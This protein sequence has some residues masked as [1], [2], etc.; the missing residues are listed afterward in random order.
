MF[1]GHLYV[2]LGEVAIQVICPFLNWI[3]CLPSVESYEFFTYFGDQTLVQDIIGKY[4]FPYSWFPFFHF[5]D[6]FPSRAEAF[7]FDD[8][9]LLLS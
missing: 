2:L 5:A 6:V 8:I 9:S 7:Y 1:I 3:V 4:L